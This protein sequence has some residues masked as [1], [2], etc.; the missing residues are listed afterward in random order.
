MNVHSGQTMVHVVTQDALSLPWT[1][2][3]NIIRTTINILTL[4]SQSDVPEKWR[5]KALSDLDP[6]AIDTVSARPLA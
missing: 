1:K 5:A 6:S 4:N 3:A 2:Y